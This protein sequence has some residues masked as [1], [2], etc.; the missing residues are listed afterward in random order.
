MQPSF[1]T[2]AANEYILTSKHAYTL[3]FL[4]ALYRHLYRPAV[5]S[6]YRLA[7]A[8]T[9]K[10]FAQQRYRQIN[11]WHIAGRTCLLK[12]GPTLLI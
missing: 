11:H 4:S 2:K 10:W 1:C 5:A 6:E 7:V 3:S 9:G 12:N 8:T